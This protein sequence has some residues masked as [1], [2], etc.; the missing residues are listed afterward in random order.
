MSADVRYPPLRGTKI[1]P[2]DDTTCWY[3]YFK[4]QNGGSEPT[5]AQADEVDATKQTCASRFRI[6]GRTAVRLP[7]GEMCGKPGYAWKI[8]L[9]AGVQ[10]VCAGCDTLHGPVIRPFD[11]DPKF[12]ENM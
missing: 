5:D 12:W 3:E 6:N 7:A 8:G 2:A 10:V 1:V 9:L 4:A 11:R